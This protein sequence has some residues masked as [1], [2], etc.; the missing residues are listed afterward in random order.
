MHSAGMVRA[1]TS[2]KSTG[3]PW[4]SIARTFELAGELI[5]A[6]I[7]HTPPIMSR[8]KT[9]AKTAETLDMGREIVYGKSSLRSQEEGPV[10][11][12]GEAKS[13]RRAP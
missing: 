6:I 9:A 12:P 7:L 10:D 1:A 8:R 4:K 2:F 11:E 3:L 13:E 5:E